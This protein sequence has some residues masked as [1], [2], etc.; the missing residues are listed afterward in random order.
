MENKDKLLVKNTIE[1]SF[2]NDK[3]DITTDNILEIIKTTKPMAIALKDKIEELRK[4]LEK[5]DVKNASR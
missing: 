1:K 3:K 5:L 2:I 4:S